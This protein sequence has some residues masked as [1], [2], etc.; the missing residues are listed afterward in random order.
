MVMPSPARKNCSFCG[1]GF[2]EVNV[3]IAGPV[4]YICNTCI[5]ACTN[6]LETQRDAKGK[7]PTGQELAQ[8][9]LDEFVKRHLGLAGAD[10]KTPL[11]V[12]DIVKKF[13]QIA[14]QLPPSS[15]TKSE[16][17]PPT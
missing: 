13:K 1:K 15:P 5:N 12:G 3:L 10:T 2:K 11:T 9:T 17:L 6:V 14:W 7:Q 8:L 4:T 16:T